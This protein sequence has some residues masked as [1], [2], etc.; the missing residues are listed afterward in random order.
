MTEIFLLL[1]I[2]AVLG[3]WVARLS[4]KVIQ[5]EYEICTA[6]LHFEKEYREVLLIV[7]KGINDNSQAYCGLT[8][9]MAKHTAENMRNIAQLQKSFIEYRQLINNIVLDQGRYIKKGE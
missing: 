5:L 9:L 7:Q 1:M 3:V 8:S 6:Q 4:R 2:I